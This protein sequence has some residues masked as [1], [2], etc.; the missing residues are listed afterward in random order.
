M[1]HLVL[2][3]LTLSFLA[4]CGAKNTT[5][6]G[7]R[8]LPEPEKAVIPQ[9]AP[10][11]PDSIQWITLDG[12]QSQL[13]FNPR[14]DILFVIDNS[15]SMKSAEENLVRNVNYFASGLK[16][17]KM[18]DYHIG[19]TSVWDSS[20]RYIT[21]KNNIYGVGELRNLKTKAG[22]TLDE[23]YVSKSVEAKEDTLASTL[24]IGIAPYVAGGPEREEV[25]SPISE[26]LH[27]SGHGA[28]NDGFFRDDAQ[29]VVVI[30]TDAD[31]G[32]DTLTPEQ[33]AQQLFDFKAGK[34]DRVS[35]YAALV[36]SSDPEESKDWGLRI[37]PR[38][39]PEC[40]EF[41]GAVAIKRNGNCKAGFAPERLEQFV[42]AANVEHGSAKEI[43]NQHIMS[44]VQKDFGQDL[45]KIGNDIVVRTLAKKILLDQR[46]RLDEK[47]Q[48]MVRVRYGSPEALAQGKGQIIPQKQKGGWVYDADDNSIVL[49]GDVAYEYQE[50]ARFAVD[51]VPVT[52]SSK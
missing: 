22:V 15:D 7:R 1:K 44:L 4:A 28:V 39:H 46:P 50:N 36:K 5:I 34:R 12:G 42:L 37:H 47:S 33:L 51:L 38:Y 49:A 25:F 3:I 23:R 16:K 52:I 32:T 19:V 2:S 26:A 17:N 41:K 30:L 48:L 43:R 8:D 35:V 21:N 27:K 31:D 40:F 10:I 14:V 29:L 13:E 45:S 20:E 9:Y 11:A 18:I 24:N 6:T